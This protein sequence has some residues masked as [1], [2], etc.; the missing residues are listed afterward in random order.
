MK[1]SNRLMLL[2]GFAGLLLGL[3]AP[4][5][6]DVGPWQNADSNKDG[7]IDRAEFDAQGAAR[8]KALDANGDGFVT[9]DEMKAFHEAQRAKFDAAKGEM[10]GKF[11]KRFDKDSDGKISATEWPKDGRLKFEK[12]DA[13]SDGFVTAEE[14]TEAHKSRDGKMGGHK[15]DPKDRFAKL[16]ADKDGKLSSSEWSAMGDKM[17][18]RL[19]DNKDG[20]ISTDELP[21][22]GKHKPQDGG[23]AVQ[24]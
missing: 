9:Q 1:N 20:K 19:D 4:A 22:H 5:F 7:T 17:F 8:F 16:D 11:L 15:G 2:G 13:N 10:G 24:P 6:A 21:K 18:A 3:A 23:P 12:V 14:M